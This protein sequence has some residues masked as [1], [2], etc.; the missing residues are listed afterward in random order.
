MGWEKKIVSAVIDKILH[1]TSQGRTIKRLV[2]EAKE[3][4]VVA[5]AMVGPYKLYLHH[6]G[7]W[8]LVVIPTPKQPL[9]A[10]QKLAPIGV[11]WR[12]GADQT[13]LVVSRALGAEDFERVE[14]D[15]E[16][17]EMQREADMLS[18]AYNRDELN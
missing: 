17:K 14:P 9:S 10:E 18:F 6:L 2:A 13:A 3:A 16:V 7:G 8:H 15:E 12:E 11:T 1:R 4:D 5:K